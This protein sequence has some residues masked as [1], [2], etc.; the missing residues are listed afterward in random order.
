MPLS[1]QVK[2]KKPKS[3]IEMVWDT[4][5]EVQ[6]FSFLI[7]TIAIKRKDEQHHSKALWPYLPLQSP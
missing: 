1:N 5:L 2:E 3:G 4:V 6:C 7:P